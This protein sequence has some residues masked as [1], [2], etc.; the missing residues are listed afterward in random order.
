MLCL[1][2]SDGN[3]SE[4]YCFNGPRLKKLHDKPRTET[5]VLVSFFSYIS[6]VYEEQRKSIFVPKFHKRHNLVQKQ[7]YWSGFFSYI[8]RVHAGVNIDPKFPKRCYFVNHSIWGSQYLFLNFTNVI[9]SY[10]NSCIDLGFFL[11]HQ[12]STCGCQYWP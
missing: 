6:I 11:I 3:G 5:V 9:T 7:L 1:P 2:L 8:S 4:M 12:Q 10:R